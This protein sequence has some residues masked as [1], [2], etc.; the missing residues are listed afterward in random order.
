MQHYAWSL[1]SLRD[2]VVS[3]LDSNPEFFPLSCEIVGK[4]FNLF[5]PQFPCLLYIP[6]R[7]FLIKELKCSVQNL[8][9]NK[10]PVKIHYHHH[11]RQIKM[12]R[13]LFP[14]LSQCPGGVEGLQGGH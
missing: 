1:Q 11:H 14:Q 6:N 10:Q 12:K 2:R 4:S 13:E 3:H 9:L 5:A 7:V 8:T